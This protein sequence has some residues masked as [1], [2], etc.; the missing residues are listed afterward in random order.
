MAEGVTKR[1]GAVAVLALVA[2][3]SSA[4][5]IRQSRE[6]VIRALAPADLAGQI[7]APP[8]QATP[9]TAPTL[10]ASSAPV[11]G[12]GGVSPSASGA[13]GVAPPNPTPPAAGATT[14]PGSA[15]A[16]AA[17][18]ISSAPGQRTA[19]SATKGGTASSGS[20]PDG[21]G[22]GGTGAPA[23]NA[24]AG[25]TAATA[26]PVLLGHIGE[27]SGVVGSSL[28]TGLA[29]IGAWA[30]WV[31]DNGGLAGHPVRLVTAD[32]GSDPGKAF[33]LAK[34][35]VERDR[36]IAFVGN[37]TPLSGSGYAE[38]IAGK[39]VPI[40]GGDLQ[41]DAHWR[42]NPMFF[43]EGPTLETITT[44]MLHIAA[45]AGKPK[46][47]L[48]FCQ[49][50]AAC[51]QINE[52]MKKS[53]NQRRAGA[54]LVYEAQISL[55]APDYTAECLQAQQ[56]GAEALVMAADANSQSRI[57]RSC[58][59]Q[60]FR[61]MYLAQGVAVTDAA[62]DDPNLEGF[63]APQFTFPWPATDTAA[64][65]VFQD[66]MRRYAPNATVGGTGTQAW[67]SGML[68]KA[69]SVALP[70]S[71]TSADLLR[72]LW[73]V[74]NESLGGLA[75]PLTFAEGALPET[76]Q[77]YFVVS[78]KARRWTAPDGSRYRCLPA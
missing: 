2:M 31:N 66:A 38:Y 62:R 13:A 22:P 10:G 75:V 68:L 11:P 24:P 17:G 36:V 34:S 69:A 4:C 26:A 70:A 42:G 20:D 43:P 6:D 3:T 61:P 28:S 21:A 37:I 64:S 9:A 44:G 32:S 16:T 58:A 47:A 50:A 53:D 19:G 54:S 59:Q 57:A 35:M 55:A 14:K 60:G 25:P 76:P 49:E 41:I 51:R 39:K 33:A 15:A 30:R 29:A 72:G 27:Y 7:S 74:K 48:L 8:P 78:V 77:C 67:A 5:G 45:S 63:T 71:P 1:V 65:R 73:S 56:R 40:V 23:A 18:P 12:S 46:V 52:Y